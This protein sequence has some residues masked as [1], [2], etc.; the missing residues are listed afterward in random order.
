MS[1]MK[2][3][4]IARSRDPDQAGVMLAWLIRNNQK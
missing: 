1:I 2:N 4:A 3:G